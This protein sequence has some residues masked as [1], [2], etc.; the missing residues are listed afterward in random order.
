MHLHNKLFC[1]SWQPIV[2]FNE[3]LNNKQADQPA[4][5]LEFLASYSVEHFRL[6]LYAQ[7]VTTVNDY[8]T[9]LFIFPKRRK[10]LP[11]FQLNQLFL[12]IRIQLTF[13]I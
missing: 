1:I 13:S 9:L 4:Y 10:K 11:P 5:Y 12:L 2:F 6:I 8:K 3:K 7:H